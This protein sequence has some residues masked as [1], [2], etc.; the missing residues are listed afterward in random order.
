MD[1]ADCGSPERLLEVLFRYYSDLP[2]RVPIE[3][4]AADVG[5]L[6]FRTLEADGFIGG[7]V[8]DPEKNSGIILVKDGLPEK[9]RRYTQGHELG[10]FLIP[11]HGY[12]R[13]CRKQ[14]LEENS[15]TT[16]YQ[17]QEAEANRFSAGLLMPKPMFVKDMDVL[18][19]ADASHI[20]RLSDLYNVSME[21]VANRYVELASDSCAVI[22][23]RDG[24]VRYGR[25]SRSF[26]PLALR[27]GSPLPERSLTR[28]YAQVGSTSSWAEHHGG[29][30]V[31]VQPGVRA[32]TVLEQAVC[33]ANGFKVTLLYIDDEEEE[34]RGEADDLSARWSA[35]LR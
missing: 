33:Q 25:A 26:P 21:A 20:R 2:R 1:L 16:A 10:H 22:F 6:E 35:R 3:T 29:M 14:D 30:W 17:R 15:R 4:I 5:I 19:T 32:P 7:L 34:E 31:E 12:Q 24:T 23:S 28:R 18:G 27:K 11:S 8:A 9:R 13:Q